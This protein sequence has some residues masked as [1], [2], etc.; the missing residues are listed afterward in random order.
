MAT[1]SKKSKQRQFDLPWILATVMTIAL[2][3]IAPRLGADTTGH[4]ITIMLLMVMWG[5]F[6]YGLS[7]RLSI[8]NYAFWL[9][10]VVSIG[11]TIYLGY[12]VWP[13]TLEAKPGTLVF[14][15]GLPGGNEEYLIS[16]TNKSDSDIYLAEL[17]ITVPNRD[18]SDPR[19]FFDIDPPASSRKPIGEATGDAA[20][21]A[22]IMGLL[23]HD[24]SLN[25]IFVLSVAHMA[26]HETREFYLIHT[27]TGDA[28]A[29]VE[30]GF[31]TTD[32]QPV[33]VGEH[34]WGRKFRYSKKTSGKCRPF[35]FLIDRE[36]LKGIYFWN[37]GH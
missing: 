17:D 36:A 12:F 15:Q 2:L 14:H 18:R 16:L 25:P 13:Y 8:H 10:A 3:L 33:S 35:T 21:Y 34:Q 23:C 9:V 1:R 5:A 11:A 7:E 24:E 20:R 19:V 31:F 37:P 4:V 22:D 27:E 29:S 26:S 28:T 32:P 6:V 30:S